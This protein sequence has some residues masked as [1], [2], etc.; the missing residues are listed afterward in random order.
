ME[1]EGEKSATQTVLKYNDELKLIY[2][3]DNYIGFVKVNES[4]VNYVHHC[5]N[6]LEEK[7]LC[8]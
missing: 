8:N 4:V 6:K 3:Y 2:N 5:V 7:N 1:S